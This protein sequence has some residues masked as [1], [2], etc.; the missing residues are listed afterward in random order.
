MAS[1]E[2][3]NLRIELPRVTEAHVR[4]VGGEVAITAGAGPARLEAEVLRGE[5]IRVEVDNGVLTI[6]HEPERWVSG[7]S[8]G[9]ITSL[10]SLAAIGRNVQRSH[11]AVVTLTI[12]ADAPVNVRTVSADV[13]VAGARAG[14]SVTSV[15]GRVTASDVAGDLSVRAVSGSI[16]AQAVEGKVS[17]NTVSGGATVTGQVP[18]LT[19]RSVSGDLTFDLDEAGDVAISTVSGE[20]LLRLPADA[21]MHLD[22]TTM[23]GHL[24]SAFPVDGATGARR[25][26]AGDVGESPSATVS[27]RTV[28]GDV[29]VLRK[30]RVTADAGSD[31]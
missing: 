8:W 30:A 18:D 28:S 13:V 10:G 31:R 12:P 6:V 21:S 19:G 14:A 27:V 11:E 17:I 24:D 22:L 3:E 15:S 5:A 2:G 9:S 4:I 25:R 29:A 16:D 23:S 7:I 26:L 20:V 1:W